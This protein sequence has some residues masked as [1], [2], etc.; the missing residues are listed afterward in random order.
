DR[1]ILRGGYTGKQFDYGAICMGTSWAA[2]LPAAVPSGDVPP[3]VE[4][5]GVS[6]NHY[7]NFLFRGAAGQSYSILTSSNLAV[8]PDDW[9]QVG[10]GTFGFEPISF[11]YDMPQNEVCRFFQIAIR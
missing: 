5:V 2:V 11:G 3:L 1:F 8:P 9:A 4:S 6:A 7:L 10:S